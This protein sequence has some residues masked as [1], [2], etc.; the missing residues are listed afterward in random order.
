VSIPVRDVDEVVTVLREQV[1]ALYAGSAHPPSLVRVTARDVA[2]EA[3]WPQTVSAVPAVL[4]SPA[5]LLAEVAAEPRQDT[6]VAISAP[7]VGTF[8]RAP[9]PGG[10][11]FVAEGDTV[12]VGQQIGIVEAM[13]LMIPVEAD[14]AG[15]IVEFLV[16]DGT[17]VEHGQRLLV[18]QP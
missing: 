1:L 6:G 2:V 12:R 3:E 18:L 16:P 15:R 10:A 5:P 14:H 11:P 13:K 9:E 4:A 17:T 7:T 8:Y